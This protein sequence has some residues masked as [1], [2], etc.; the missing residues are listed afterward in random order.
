MERTKVFVSYSH[1]D[2]A[3]KDRVMMHLG[4]LEAE[5]LLHVWTDRRI[6]IGEDWQAKIDSAMSEARVA[7]LLVTASFLTSQFILNTEVPRLLQLHAQR[8]MLVL[9]VVAR[10][11]AWKLVTW[12][13]SRQVRPR[14]GRPLAAGGEVE[15]DLDLTAL[16]YEVA[17]LIGRVGGEAVV[18]ELATLD[19]LRVRR[20]RPIVDSTP[21]M[22]SDPTD[23]SGTAASIDAA[24]R[25]LEDVVEAS[26]ESGPTAPRLVLYVIKE[27]IS[28]GAPIYNAGSALGCALVYLHAARLILGLLGGGVQHPSHGQAVES[29]RQILT[30]AAVPT[31]ALTYR[32]ADHVAWKLRHAFDEILQAAAKGSGREWS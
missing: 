6:Q 31:E 8:R 5:G 18:S 28:H 22:R 23:T 2:E 16:A 25:A 14:D 26:Q 29:A 17:A 15:V 19:R 1:Q 4:V 9:P 3:W 12:L 27:A 20:E 21:G 11:C 7:L 13:A 30:A 24:Y 32:N 10:P